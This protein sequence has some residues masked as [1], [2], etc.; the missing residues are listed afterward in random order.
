MKNLRKEF[1]FIII[2]GF[3][4]IVSQLV[5]IR[6]MFIIYYGNEFTLGIILANWL[7]LEA[8]GSFYLGRKI[9]NYNILIILFI[10]FLPI[11]LTILRNLKNIFSLP[12]GQTIPIHLIFLSSLLILFPVSI[13]HGALFTSFAQ[14]LSYEKSIILTYIYETLGTIFGGLIFTFLLIKYLNSFSIIALTIF[15]NLLIL[16]DYKNYKS[17]FLLIPY[18]LFLFFLGKIEKKTIENQWQNRKIVY[19]H[20]SL[21]GNITILKDKEQY[22]LFHNS[23][24]IITT[25]TPNILSSQDFIHLPFLLY[26]SQ[27]KEKDLKILFI[28]GGLGGNIYELLRYKDIEIDYLEI[29]PEIFQALKKFR[30]DLT[31][32]ELKSKELKT[33]HLDARY[34]LR[35]Y[36]K[37]YDLIYLGIKEIVDLQISRLFTLEFFKIIKN[38]LKEKGLFIFSL[39]SSLTYLP[40]ELKLLNKS[41][42]NTLERVF[43]NILIIPGEENIFIATDNKNISKDKLPF[44]IESSLRYL[45][46]KDNLIINENYLKLRLSQ[47]YFDFFNSQ[48]KDI[49][50]KINTDFSPIALYYFLSYFNSHFSPFFQKLFLFFQKIKFSFLLLFIILFAFFFNFFKKS[51]RRSI[52]FLIFSTGFYGLISSLLISFSFQIVYGYLYYSLGLLTTS[53]MAGIAFGSYFT[54]TKNRVKPYFSLLLFEI[55]LLLF[56]LFFLLFIFQLKMIY[57]FPPILFILLAFISGFLCGGEFSLTTFLY[58]EKNK[59]KI[60]GVLYSADLIGGFLGGIFGSSFLIPLF[61]IYHTLL[62]IITLKFL[63]LLFFLITQR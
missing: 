18:L 25:P 50:G 46:D 13:T 30:T 1:I 29:D 4:G 48:I 47:N 10:I 53:F 2:T 51:K 40:I 17:F 24:P 33:Y 7:I 5:L 34:F 6:E 15:L 32:K 16:I 38:H 49:E 27:N 62:I 52:I 55:F 37:N 26:L 36:K 11:S 63:S 22:T 21:Y 14:Y 54:F 58:E 42:I 57:K 8:L 59:G 28:S 39:P 23:I 45:E 43:S 44:L 60:A 56:L 31:E 61:G 9:K 19:Y 3:S 12:F 20:N 41:L 35:R